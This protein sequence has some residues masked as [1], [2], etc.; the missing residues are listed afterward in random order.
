MAAEALEQQLWPLAEGTFASQ[1]LQ[2][3]PLPQFVQLYHSMLL[4]A[5]FA[6]SSSSG[7]SGDS[8][9]GQA[10]TARLLSALAFG[11]QLLA[12]L[13]RHLATS[14]GLPLEAPL[15]ASWV[16]SCWLQLDCHGGA[17]RGWEV[18]TLRRG[19]AGLQPEAAAQ[20]GLF[21]RVYCHHLA[22]VDDWEFWERQQPFSLGQQRAIAAALNTLV[23]RTQLPDNSSGGGRSGPS[24]L[25][26]RSGSLGRDY[27][28]LQQAAP[29][30]H[31]AL[32]ERDARRQFCPP[33]LWLEPYH[34]L[35]GST[36]SAAAQQ[37]QQAQQVSG[38]AV[39]RALLATEDDGSS[40]GQP[41]R[42]ASSPRGGAAGAA[43]AGGVGAAAASRPAAVAAILTAAPQCV[44]FEE[45]VSVFRALIDADKE[46]CGY[47][48][49]P[50]DGGARPM[51]LTIRRGYVLE[52]AAA[53]LGRM[54][55][56]VKSRLAITFI[57]QQG[58]Q[59][60]GIDMGGLMK[61]F[62]ESV[63]SAGFDPNR[64]L[65]AATPDG[66]AYPNPLAERLDGGLAALE[67]LGLV[68]GR[69]LYEGVLLDCP[70]APFFVSRLQGRWPLFD[71]LQ[72]LDPEVYRSLLKRYNGPVEDLCLDF[73]VE[74]DFLGSTV[75]EE[76][77]PGGSRLA[78]TQGNLLQYVY[79]VADWHLNKRLGTAAAAF[80]RGLSQVI[81]S[82]WLRLFSPREVNQLLGGGEAAA[83]N[84]DDMQAHT[85]YSNGYSSSS[86]TVKHFWSVVRNLSQEDQRSLL[87]FVTSCSR[88]PLGGFKHL[89]PPLTIHKVDCGASLLAA[90]G[91]KD[92][93]RLPTASTC[94]NTLKASA[95][96]QQTT[97]CLPN[98]R[99]SATLREKLLYAIK[100]GAGF[101]LS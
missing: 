35:I 57:N 72:A 42:P 79:L 17:T 4:L 89:H 83:L 8:K 49:A 69:A 26:G 33:A 37:A 75:S 30:L 58:L 27:R 54:G 81:P 40:D 85:V 46:R 24:Q 63:V 3:L 53:Q 16:F 10:A 34:H 66:Q 78:V 70:L 65:F 6:K 95:C 44:P 67:T 55:C 77:V 31:R 20:L 22:V 13:W 91:G 23:F 36:P 60:A 15:Q 62:L 38:A 11:T 100:S 64:G 84:I 99:R 87:K 73:T 98:F 47:H 18:A 93:D 41:G 12:R 14:I 19:I 7:S 76:L 51:P 61:E 32:Y 1:L 92:V 48:L 101:E 50:V 97:T 56:A 80:S 43:G 25:A 82:S 5:D 88:A 2:L 68:L 71:E 28:M 74:S 45:R 21:C 52:D 94:S 96:E 29:L 9:S 39:V 86:S 59:E 90:V